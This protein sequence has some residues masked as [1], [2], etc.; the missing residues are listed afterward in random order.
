MA[1]DIRAERLI[2]PFAIHH[3]NTAGWYFVCPDKMLAARKVAVFKHWVM[4]EAAMTQS[5]LDI[6]ISG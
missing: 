5:E 6:E 1:S 4:T 3:P 2:A